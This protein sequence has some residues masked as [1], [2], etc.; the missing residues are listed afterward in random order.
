MLLTH[1]VCPDC[2]ENPKCINSAHKAVPKETVLYAYKKTKV[3]ISTFKYDFN[4]GYFPRFPVMQFGNG[5]CFDYCRWTIMV[6][7]L[8]I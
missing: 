8:D 6:Y 4:T 2:Q 7:S 1:N 3:Y 5:A